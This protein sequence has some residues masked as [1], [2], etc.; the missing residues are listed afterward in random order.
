[1]GAPA[2][3][4][5]DLGAQ[6]L[7]GA[8]IMGVPSSDQ[9]RTAAFIALLAVHTVV[10]AILGWRTPHAFAPL[11]L[12]FFSNQALPALVIFGA[13]AAVW[14]RS[15][16][17]AVLSL[18]ALWLGSALTALL[19]FPFSTGRLVLIAGPLGLAMGLLAWRAANGPTVRAIAISLGVLAGIGWTAAQRAP[20]PTTHPLG[21]PLGEKEAGL[22]VPVNCGGLP[23]SVEPVLAFESCADDRFWAF[24]SDRRCPAANDFATQVRAEGA[25]TVVEAQTRFDAPVFSHLNS[26]ASVI[27]D[28]GGLLA[29]IAG[30]PAEPFPPADGPSRFAWLGDD[31]LLHTSLAAAQEKG[32]FVERAA[33]RLQ[34]DTL[35]VVLSDAEGPACRLSFETW[36][37]Q[38]SVAPSP[39][40]GWRVAQNAVEL[41]QS[42]D[43]TAS[44][45]ALSLAATSIGNGWDTVG[46]APGTYRNIVRLEPL[47]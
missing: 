23:L 34:N 43:A 32:P 20:D 11:S 28:R 26:F 1:M 29:A 22:A 45:V 16:A 39:T 4:E 44:A 31:G 30:G 17:D 24:W 25:V 12:S 2:F 13:A 7:S 6:N 41:L 18:A 33:V 46:H 38:A 9:L 14:R 37:K 42:P 19:L 36:A 3:R 40:A 21:G 27:V 47:R 15:L 8:N 35:T 5:T 10:A